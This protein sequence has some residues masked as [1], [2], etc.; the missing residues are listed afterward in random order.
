[1]MRAATKVATN[2]LAVCRRFVT[3]S[4]VDGEMDV[5]AI[6]K[7]SCQIKTLSR[8]ADFELDRLLWPVGCRTNLLLASRRD[9]TE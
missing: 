7:K 6:A 2:L 9:F 1:M 4:S 3:I 5:P 8:P